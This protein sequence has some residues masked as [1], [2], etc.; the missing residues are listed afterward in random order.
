[1]KIKLTY[2]PEGGSPREWFF[3]PENPAWDLAYVTETETGWPW[4]EFL[5][6]LSHQSHVALR[7]IV[8]AFRKRE[9]QRLTLEG[10]TVTFGE[11]DVDEVPEPK[12]PKLKKVAGGE[13]EA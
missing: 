6:K 11:I 9:E 7:A 5:D 12:K 13:G 1:M 2:T 10:V 3:D 4:M 8:Y